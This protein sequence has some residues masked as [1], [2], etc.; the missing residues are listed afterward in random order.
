MP[1]LPTASD[2]I[3]LTGTAIS[4]AVVSALINDAALVADGDCFAAYSE[5]RK[6]A[7]IKW[8]AAH[9]VASTDAGGGTLTQ[10]KLGD[11]SQS[12]ARAT[13]GE[14]LKGTMYG[15]QAL[16]LDTSGCLFR[17]GKGRATVCVI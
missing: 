15:Q 16:A 4:A 8:L 13:M 3:D 6:T 5:E 1:T 2:V 10:D 14:G 17:L 12:Y 11:A 9:L 7:I